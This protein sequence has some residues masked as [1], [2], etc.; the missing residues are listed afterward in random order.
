M[1]SSQSNSDYREPCVL[2]ITTPKENPGG[3]SQCQATGIPKIAI[4]CYFLAR[5]SWSL[6][7]A[8]GSILDSSI[9]CDGMVCASH[10][11]LGRCRE[12]SGVRRRNRSPR[13][14]RRV[15]RSL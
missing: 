6:D 15:G 7:R 8:P 12:V 1:V 5:T 3:A 10:G 4:L 13:R 11:I 2:A 14:W 9:R